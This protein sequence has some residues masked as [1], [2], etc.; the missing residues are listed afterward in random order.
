MYRLLLILLYSF[1]SLYSAG[2]AVG[3]LEE[4]NKNAILN[5]KSLENN[6]SSFL[7][8]PIP[9]SNP[10]L[11]TGLNVVSLFMHAPRD[12]ESLTPTTA[13]AALYSTNDSWMLG[14]FHE[15]YW[16]KGKNR[17]KLGLAT[18]VLNLK[19]YGIGNADKESAIDYK[20]SASPIVARYQRQIPALNNFYFGVQYIALIGKIES[21]EI[22]TPS[23]GS[24]QASALGVVGTYDTRDE[25][26]FP[27]EG[28]YSEVILNHYGESLGSSFELTQFKSFATYYLPHLKG[29]TLATKVEF[30]YNSSNQPFF[31]LPS[32]SLRGFDRTKYLDKTIIQAQSEERYRFSKRFVGVAFVGA[33]SYGDTLSDFSKDSLVVSYGAGIRYQ[34]LEDKKINLSVDAA[35]SDDDSAIYLRLGEAF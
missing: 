30:K 16:D 7:V 12:E 9:F 18:S 19:Y 31:L 10:T 6:E 17:V 25:I 3:A 20:M 13:V 27:T 5:S 26:Y 23:D 29:S 1:S 8:A 28:L 33:G 35:F 22:Q 2:N 34:I 4:E 14:I 32:I 11:G 15:D 24:F 21:E